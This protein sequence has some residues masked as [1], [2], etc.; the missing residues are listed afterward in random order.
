MGAAKI[1]HLYALRIRAL[2]KARMLSL[3]EY[4]RETGHDSGKRIGAFLRGE[5]VMRLDD[6]AWAD[7]ILGD[8]SEQAVRDAAIER[9]KNDALENEVSRRLLAGEKNS[10]LSASPDPQPQVLRELIT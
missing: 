10:P 6:L 9:R 4:A 5:V 1:Q 2:L 8:V 7:L 3:A